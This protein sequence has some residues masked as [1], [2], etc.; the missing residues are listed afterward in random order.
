MYKCIKKMYKEEKFRD[1]E[2][3][4]ELDRQFFTYFRQKKGKKDNF[5]AI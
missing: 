2:N 4:M 3:K 1:S 5:R